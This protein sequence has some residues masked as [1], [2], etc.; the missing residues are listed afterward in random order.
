MTGPPG[1]LDPYHTYKR[2]AKS[3]TA[4]TSAAATNKRVRG[5][6]RAEPR[7]LVKRLAP[8]YQPQDAISLEGRVGRIPHPP[9]RTPFAR[10]PHRATAVVASDSLERIT[11]EIIVC[12]KCPRLVRY[13][14]SVARVKRAS[15]RDWTYWGRPVPGFGD[16]KARLL[17]VGLAPAAHGGNRTG[18]PFTGDRSGDWLYRALHRAGFA[19]QPTSVSRDD[20]LALRDCYIAASVRCAPPQN[21]PTRT[22]FARCQP[23]LERELMLLPQAQVVIVLGAVAMRAFL[24]A[25]KSTNHQVGTPLP[26]FRHG[27]SWS[28]PPITLMA[29]YHPSQR[30]TQTGLLTEPMFDRVFREARRIMAD[31]PGHGRSKAGSQP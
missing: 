27:G 19:N 6:T 17:I 13:R 21:K 28:L 26:K 14:E 18:R 25:W 20:G 24:S 12:R 11:S 15:Y 29:S 5:C 8:P 9:G 1:R 3:K 23:F 10:R 16:P 22:E 4:A 30:N 7:P 2:P 31:L